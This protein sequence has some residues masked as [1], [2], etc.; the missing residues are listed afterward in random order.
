MDSEK[1]I[2]HLKEAHG[3]VA[4]AITDGWSP[5]ISGVLKAPS[6]EPGFLAMEKSEHMICEISNDEYVHLNYSI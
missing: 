1:Y 4:Y 6:D 5:L 2:V 3:I